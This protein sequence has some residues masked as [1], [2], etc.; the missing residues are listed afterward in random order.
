MAQATS[1]RCI[2]SALP[3]QVFMIH[4]IKLPL[5]NGLHLLLEKG[6]GISVRWES[7]K[8]IRLAFRN[9]GK[10]PEPTM[11]NTWHPNTHNL[12]LLRTWA[13]EK[14]PYLAR[15]KNVINF[16]IIIHAF[17]PPWRWIMETT[18]RDALAMDWDSC[19][20]G[21]RNLRT[22]RDDFACR[23]Q[24]NEARRGFIRRLFL[25]LIVLH[26]LPPWRWMVKAMLAKAKGMTW[27]DR[28][29]GHSTMPNWP[30]WVEDAN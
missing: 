9:M 15:F 3:M 29:Y 2:Y 27:E 10:L 22:S 26:F 7:I 25:V 21:V 5:L 17:D 14:Y 13:F 8:Q 19:F 23:C 4:A 18:L 11:E 6:H 1:R 28:M 20:Q 30:W 16:A 24:I 12:I